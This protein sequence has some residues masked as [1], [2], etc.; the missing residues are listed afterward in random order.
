MLIAAPV[1]A[2]PVALGASESWDPYGVAARRWRWPFL[3][4]WA[5]H[6][7]NAGGQDWKRERHC[8]GKDSKLG[9]DSSG[10]LGRDGLIPNLT[11]LT[12]RRARK[13]QVAS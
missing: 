1:P 10:R 5:G 7:D 13:F 4:V 8:Q 6:P 9:H 11:P 12:N 2:V 3:D